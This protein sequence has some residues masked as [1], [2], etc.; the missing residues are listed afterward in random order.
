MPMVIIR[1]IIDD[2]T[3]ARCQIIDIISSMLNKKLFLIKEKRQDERF[4]CLTQLLHYAQ[5]LKEILQ[6]RA[7]LSIRNHNAA[8]LSEYFPSKRFCASNGRIM[9]K[10][11]TWFFASYPSIVFHFHIRRELVKRSHQLPI[12]VRPFHHCRVSYLASMTPRCYTV[13]QHEVL[14][15]RPHSESILEFEH[16]YEREPRTK[17]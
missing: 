3:C 12:V 11:W 16:K 4:G 10:W 13:I 2:I 9:H 6:N 17:C 1:T 14:E 5:M 15:Y 7:L 8:E